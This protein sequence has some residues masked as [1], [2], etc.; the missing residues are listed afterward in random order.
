MCI[1]DIQSNISLSHLS[2]LCCLYSLSLLSF[3]PSLTTRCVFFYSV[4]V[5]RT[6]PVCLSVCLSPTFSDTLKYSCLTEMSS[7]GEKRI[8]DDHTWPLSWQLF[9]LL[10]VPVRGEE[11]EEGGEGANTNT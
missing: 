10:C 4:S 6:L 2:R 11:E 9:V 8:D 5:S 3:P 7:A 1:S